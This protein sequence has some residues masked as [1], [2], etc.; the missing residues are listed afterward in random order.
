MTSQRCEYCVCEHDERVTCPEYMRRE[1]V[2]DDL[3]D[4][5]VTV[6]VDP[7][8]I[9]PVPI[10]PHDACHPWGQSPMGWWREAVPDDPVDALPDDTQLPLDTWNA[11]VDA[12]LAEVAAYQATLDEETHT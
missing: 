4:D 7:V 9:G 6:F 11:K 3:D 5:I 8:R 1:I 10:D 12:L 2:S